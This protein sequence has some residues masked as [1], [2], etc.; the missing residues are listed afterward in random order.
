METFVYGGTMGFYPGLADTG[1]DQAAG[2]PALELVSS[3]ALT[4]C[5]SAAVTRRSPTVLSAP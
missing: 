5:P 3:A 1:R 4:M 2:A